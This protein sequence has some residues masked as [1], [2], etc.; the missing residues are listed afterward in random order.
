[1]CSDAGAVISVDGISKFFEIY[2][3]PSYRL[4]QMIFRGRR[5]F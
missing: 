1:M 4:W 2:P 3:K 5:R